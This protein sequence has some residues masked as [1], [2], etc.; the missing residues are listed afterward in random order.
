VKRRVR[1]GVCNLIKFFVLSLEKGLD[2]DI[3][4]TSKRLHPA[5]AR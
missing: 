4:L 5:L 2:G 3:T 1:K